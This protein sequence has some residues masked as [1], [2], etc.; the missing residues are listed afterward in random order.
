MQTKLV[1]TLSVI[2]LDMPFVVFVELL[3]FKDITYVKVAVVALAAKVV[4]L[5]AMVMLLDVIFGHVV[6]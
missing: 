5:A 4:A 6:V 2:G 1:F 3:D